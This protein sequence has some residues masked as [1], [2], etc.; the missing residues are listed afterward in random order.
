MGYTRHHAIIVTSCDLDLLAKARA[1]AL[2]LFSSVTKCVRSPINMYDTFLVVPDGSNE[3]WAESDAGDK[4]R[5]AFKE[6]LHAQA[7]EDGSTLLDWIEVQYGDDEFE[8][9][10]CAD[11]Y[12]LM[13]KRAKTPPRGRTGKRKVRE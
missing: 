5:T 13:R 4:A 11:S 6:W 7:F 8:T 3:G 9:K 10:I 1:K 12:Q 2:S